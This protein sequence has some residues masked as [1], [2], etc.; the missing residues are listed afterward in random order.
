[1][2]H[3]WWELDNQLENEGKMGNLTV[4]EFETREALVAKRDL[5][6]KSFIEL[7]P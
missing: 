7:L 6:R 2:Y 4:N 3:A 1:M 5:S